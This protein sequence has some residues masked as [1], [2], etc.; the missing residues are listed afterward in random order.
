MYIREKPNKSGVI[1]VQIID[2][3][4]GKYRLVKTV[5]S[6]A[7]PLKVKVLLQEARRQMA[8]LTGQGSLNFDIGREN[9]LIDLFFNGINDIRLVGPELLLG[10]LFDDIGFGKIKDELFR[11]LVIARLCH[12]V[13]KLKT[14]DY[15]YK[16]KGISVDV[17][18]IYRYLDKLHNKQKEQV[19]QISY[20]HTL[21]VLDDKISV[22]FYDVT[23]LYFEIE[24]QDD[25]RKTGFSKDGK[26]QHPQILLGLLVS[27]G[28][29]PLAY[30]IFEG[31]KYEGHTMLPVIE[32]FKALYKLD[33]L[34]VV[35]DAGLLSNSNI[36]ELQSKQY[37]Y[38]LGARIKNEAHELQQQILA[39]PRQNAQCTELD[40]DEYSRLI[41]SYSQARAGKDAVNRKRGLE[42]LE[43]SL[44]KGKLTKQ[45]INNRGYNKYLRM[46]G[47]ITIS[48]DY[49]K[50]KDDA[51]WDG[52]KGYITNTLL[53]K[54]KVIEQYGNLWKIE[55]AF[56]GKQKIMQSNQ[57]KPSMMSSKHA[58]A[59]HNH[60]T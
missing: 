21:K 41:I 25:L 12:P 18:R 1:S 53:L 28:G 37:E 52:L 27:I 51:K 48:I 29:Y 4:T 47:D 24:D 3:S 45:N 32:A 58:L 22:V 57:H 49:D 34:I 44:Q 23:T 60:F 56:Y 43:R 31:N 42:K 7:D 50:W 13:S 5:G 14:T 20:S 19:Q 59:L 33:K 55:K 16:F 30:E 38:I 15:L 10:K 39:L 8:K 40:R 35:A 6:S 54:E 46:E 36:I 17:E 2:K 11:H 9:E 26:H